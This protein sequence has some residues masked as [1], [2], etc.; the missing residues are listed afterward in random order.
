MRKYPSQYDAQVLL[1]IMNAKGVYT[2]A[3]T[4]AFRKL[5]EDFN[6]MPKNWGKLYDK[7]F[8]EKSPW[9]Y[10]TNKAVRTIVW[11]KDKAEKLGIK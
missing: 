3:A 6:S 5:G 11:D 2:G 10:E 4:G 1:D 7:A 8:G 9:T